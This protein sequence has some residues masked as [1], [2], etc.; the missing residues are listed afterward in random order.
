[1]E[2]A[3][4]SYQQRKKRMHPKPCRG[5]N[6]GDEG[7]QNEEQSGCHTVIFLLGSRNDLAGLVFRAEK[8]AYLRTIIKYPQENRACIE[9]QTALWRCIVAL[10]IVKTCDI[11]RKSSHSKFENSRRNVNLHHFKLAQYD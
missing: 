11:D 4:R 1:M 10:E 9:P 8:I 5:N 6:H 2:D 3:D 7:N